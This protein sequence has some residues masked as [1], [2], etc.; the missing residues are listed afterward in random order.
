M[1]GRAASG[2]GSRLEIL[3]TDGSLGMGS[4]PVGVTPA[5]RPQAGVNSGKWSRQG[6]EREAAGWN[7][8][9]IGG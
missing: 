9:Y 5:R 6:E 3:G 8:T 7:L 4:M 1:I 2:G